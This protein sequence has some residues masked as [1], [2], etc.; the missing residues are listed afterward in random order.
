MRRNQTHC[1]K[2]VKHNGHT[3]ELQK[4]T[5]KTFGDVNS[6]GSFKCKV[7]GL[8]AG[9][10]RNAWREWYG[11]GSEIHCGIAVAKEVMDS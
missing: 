8:S 7:C 4:T 10:E 3:F 9:A 11:E 5:R 1:A 6:W 2:I